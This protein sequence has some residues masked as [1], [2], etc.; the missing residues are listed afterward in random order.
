MSLV[1]AWG[2][3]RE[4]RGGEKGGREKEGGEEGGGER[5]R[6]ENKGGRRE[7]GVRW[8]KEVRSTGGRRGG[9]VGGG[10]WHTF[11]IVI[12]SEFALSDG[13][14]IVIHVTTTRPGS[15]GG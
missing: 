2:E 9:E 10:A 15:R 13:F 14:V 6:R 1:Q 5:G 3:G 4:K 11:V 12:E 7:K 8:G